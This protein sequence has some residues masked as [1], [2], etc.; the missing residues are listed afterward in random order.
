MTT[1]GLEIEFISKLSTPEIKKDLPQN[2]N[3]ISECDD[4]NVLEIISPPIDLLN[5]E[6]NKDLHRVFSLLNREEISFDESNC[7]IH[8]HY[9]V[10]YNTLDE[11]KDI[12]SNYSL[13]QKNLFK[14]VHHKRINNQW[15]LPIQQYICINNCESVK[16]IAD[17]FQ[18]GSKCFD[19]NLYSYLK[20]KTIEFRL[21]EAT[22]NINRLFSWIKLLE[23]NVWIK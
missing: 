7:G 5:I 6:R 4:T 15:C 2:W 16:E 10:Y 23:K 19:I 20:F 9:D 21:L 13:N 22:S 3:I 1:I 18:G 14:F 17:L 12:I 11:I 8:I